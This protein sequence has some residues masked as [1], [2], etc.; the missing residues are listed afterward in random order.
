MIVEI[1]ADIVFLINFLVNSAVLYIAGVLCRKNARLWRIVAGGTATAGLYTVLVFT[2][3]AAWLNIFTSF[4]IFAPGIFISL[5]PVN[6]KDFCVTLLAAYLTAFAM[7]G[8]GMAAMRIFDS[9][10][11]DILWS[12]YSFGVSRSFTPQNLIMAVVSSFVVLKLAQKY[13]FKKHLTKQAFCRFK[14]HLLDKEIELNALVDTGNS[15]IDPISQNPVIIAEFNKIEHLLP[16]PIATLFR[17]EGQNDLLALAASFS[18]G[19]FNTR[20]RMIP[21]SAIGKSGVIVGFRPDKV[22]LIDSCRG[23]T[24]PPAVQNVIIGICDFPLSSNGEYH[25]LMNPL[26]CD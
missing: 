17:E 15:L 11:R 7:G 22:E 3:I 20:I 4:I 18:E 21:Y 5:K 12:T 14:I 25:A 6:I 16:A 2:P 19:G 9:G 1:Y 10:S 23:G 13:I 8:L 26:L 24:L